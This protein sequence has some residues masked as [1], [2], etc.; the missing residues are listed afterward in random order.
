MVTVWNL[1]LAYVGFAFTFKCWLFVGCGWV[2]FWLC[3]GGL[4]VNSVD[5]V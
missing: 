5:L 1:F 4:A 2:W 3:C